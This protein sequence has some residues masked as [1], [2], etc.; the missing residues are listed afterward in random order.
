MENLSTY[1]RFTGWVKRSVTL[2]LFTIGFLI[3]LLL[4]PTS[5]LQGLIQEREYTRDNAIREVSS[6]WGNSQTVGGPIISIPYTSQYINEKGVTQ[7]KIDYAHFL[8]DELNISGSMLPE[9]R[10]RGIYVVVLYNADLNIKGT[11]NALNFEALNIPKQNYLLKDARLCLGISDNKGIKEK[12]V[13][14]DGT[15]TE[16]FGPGLPSKDIFESGIS[17]PLKLDSS[18]FSFNIK[19]NL[20]GSSDLNFLP[21]GKTTKVAITSSWPDASFQ[22]SSLPDHRDMS[23]AGFKADWQILELNRNYPQQGVGGFL[24]LRSD[25]QYRSADEEMYASGFGV[26]L[27]LPVDEYQKTM[28]SAKYGIMFIIITFLTFFFIEVI[29]GK[30]MHPLQYLLVGF[31]VCLFYVLLLSISEHLNFNNAYLISCVL[32]LALVTFYTKSIF[33]SARYGV[34]I[35]SI[36]SVL[37]LFFYSLLQLQDYALLMGSIGLLAILGTIMYLTRNID[38]YDLGKKES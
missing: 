10:K 38:W 17:V 22:G 21:L 15:S 13:F 25:N 28:R 31:A 4:I 19:L 37:Y 2:K 26:K 27:I 32:T 12:V 29:T 35:C 30:R 5:M 3:L 6:K 24:G 36:L 23:S 34:L 16:L 8:P 1:D 33:K 7:T 9:K 11:F 14:N 20:N 18:G